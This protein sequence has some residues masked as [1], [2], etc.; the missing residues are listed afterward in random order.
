MTH[1]QPTNNIIALDVGDRRIGVAIASRAARLPRP[2]VTLEN[3]ENIFRELVELLDEHTVDTVVVGLPRNLSGEDTPQTIIVRSF[4]ERLGQQISLPVYLVD[5][6]VTSKQAE[7][8]LEARKKPYTKA[9]IDA[10]SAT[11][12]LEDYLQ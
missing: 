8:E 12:I 9:D 5:E 6:A 11:L 7:A 10:L 4:A 2:L 1:H 3:G